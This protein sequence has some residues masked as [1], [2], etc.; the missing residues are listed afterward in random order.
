MSATVGFTC[1]AIMALLVV[2]DGNT[3]TVGGGIAGGVCIAIFIMATQW[4]PSMARSLT[5]L[6]EPIEIIPL[7]LKRTVVYPLCDTGL[8]CVVVVS[9]YM[10][11]RYGLN[12]TSVASI[13]LATAASMLAIISVSYLF[14]ATY[15]TGVE[16]Q[17]GVS[18]G[19]IVVRKYGGAK[20]LCYITMER[21]KD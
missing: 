8:P 7:S 20:E 18:I 14:G 13:G 4:W 9:A 21:S 3:A 2:I 15:I 6:D 5:L 10:V 16:Q 1:T 19:K 12:L 11:V 17:A